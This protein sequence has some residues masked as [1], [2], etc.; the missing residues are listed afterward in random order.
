MVKSNL[1]KFYI[2]LFMMLLAKEAVI[3]IKN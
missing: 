1:C 2:S 3:G